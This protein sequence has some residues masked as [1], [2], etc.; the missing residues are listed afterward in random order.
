MLAIRGRDHP[1]FRLCGYAGLAA[2]LG[3]CAVVLAARGLPAWGTAVLGV[4]GV[5]TFLALAMAVKVVTGRESLTYYHHEIAILG[6][7]GLALT[8]AGLPVRAG[9]DAACLALGAFLACGRIGCLA[10]GC[11]HGRPARWGVRYGPTHA[12]A[13]FPAEL[14]GVRLAPVQGIE[15]L[16]AAAIT[17]GGLASV[18]AGARPGVALVLYVAG[19][20]LARFVL[21]EIRGDTGRRRL[22]GFSEAQWTS[23]VLTT[24]AVVGAPAHTVLPTAAAATIGLAMVA[25][26]VRRRLP[27]AR[28]APGREPVP[29]SSLAG[30]AVQVRPRR[31][32][33]G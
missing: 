7:C 6:A 20:G 10:V 14:V 12:K 21:E 25:L 26:S 33:A 9:L 1:V 22:A 32:Q 17:A 5:A 27:V 24:L 11:C 23:L 28:H 16:A 13:G 15:A 31:G 4:T 29:R 19:Y 3:T 30:V 18:A 2:A 8:L